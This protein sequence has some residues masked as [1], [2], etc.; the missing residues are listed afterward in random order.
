MPRHA[1]I[2]TR[3]RDAQTMCAREEAKTDEEVNARYVRWL[4]LVLAV[5]SLIEDSV[6]TLTSEDVCS[7]KSLHYSPR[8]CFL[9]SMRVA[10]MK[11]AR[12]DAI[13]ASASPTT[14][15]MTTLND[16]H[17]R[18]FEERRR[19]ER[20]TRERTFVT[21]SE[22]SHKEVRFNELSRAFYFKVFTSLQGRR[23]VITH[24]F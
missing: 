24:G 18:T 19:R 16:F 3:E 11:I 23:K 8:A 20:K 13:R 17:I 5:R 14:S 22:S 6:T 9:A 2:K 21:S 7:T 15:K 12:I 1:S 4:F 10:R